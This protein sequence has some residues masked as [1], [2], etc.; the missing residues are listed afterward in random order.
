MRHLLQRARDA[1]ARLAGVRRHA[2]IEQ[3][4]D[5][6]MRFHIDMQTERNVSAGMS[7][8]DARRAALVA[9]G[10]PERYREATRDEYRS[11][12]LDELAQ[13]VRYAVRT[14]RRAPG[15]A[16]VVVAT[17]AVG[18]GATTAIFSVVNGVLLRPLPLRSPER[19]AWALERSGD[20]GLRLPSYPTYLDWQAQ[21]PSLRG[22]VEGMAFVRGQTATLR[23]E[24]GPDPVVVAYITP[25][26]FA[27]TGTQ[28]LVGRAFGGDEE[29]AGTEPTVVM[30][31]GL[32]RRRFGGDRSVIGT[33][34]DLNGV[35]T[36]VIGVLPPDAYPTFGELWQPIGVIEATDP[37]LRRRGARADSRTVVRIA[38]GADSARAA[39]A[40]AAVGRRLAAQYPAESEG[41]TSV[42]LTPL[43]AELLGDVRPTLLTLAGAVALVLLLAC[44]NV[45]NLLAVRA[46]GRGRE[47]AVRSALGAGRGRLSRQLLAETLVLAAC[48]GVV[49]SVVALALVRVVRHAAGSRLPRADQI[50]LDGLALLFCL[51]ISV[52]AAVIVGVSPALRAA[53]TNLTDRLRA[54]ASGS[55]GGSREAR[56]RSTLAVVQLA[57]ALTLLI[58]AGLLA[59]SF[60]RVLDV[61]LGFAAENLVAIRIQPSA[62]KVDEPAQAAALFE[63]ALEAV[64]AVPGVSDAALVNHVPVGGGNIST[65]VEVEGTRERSAG[66]TALYRT[67]SESYLRT[68]R[69]RLA[70]GRWLSADDIRSRTPVFVVNETMAKRFWPGQDPVG[71][72]VT[73]RRTAPGR[74]GL[75]EPLPGVVIG[76]VG[77]VHQFGQEA[78]V[79]PEVYVPYTVE[80][81]TWITVVARVSDPGLTVPAL[82]SAVRRVD[83]DI[84]LGGEGPSAAIRTAE[85]MVSTNIA[86]RRFAVSLVGAFSGA[87]LLLAVLGLY[88]VLAHGVAQRTR[89]MGIRAALGATAGDIVRLVVTEGAK[90]ALLGVGAGVACAVAL[91]RSIRA[92]LFQTAPEDPT[93]YLIMAAVLIA[94][95]LAASYLPARRAA[96]LDPTAA[97]RAD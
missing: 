1:L 84:P 60:R 8:A 9:F 97:I 21:A 26:F 5:D 24:A 12:F 57:L 4:L 59:Q 70:R 32:W 89:E 77:D 6:E 18:I 75:G 50:E 17:L 73:L 45:A 41:W 54:G 74:S 34:L 95:A 38:E 47:F 86:Q 82:R 56:L 2:H 78:D 39:A 10:G 3:R 71:R 27:L 53:R 16:A 81:W 62:R 28:P 51:G 30:S 87:A 79:E 43:R 15:F 20:G 13:D 40:L 22:A 80:V 36:T 31:Y 68:M 90:L 48:G 35:A 14:L 11:R 42:A 52:V 66:A 58:G 33:R 7:P 72:R 49:G 46:A 91:A 83:P 23:G 44:A 76:V 19:L 96:R 88:G 37:V 25:G 64:R 92:M 61:P 93:A 29:R 94:A 65:P 67:A 69:M 63:R 55:V 85:S